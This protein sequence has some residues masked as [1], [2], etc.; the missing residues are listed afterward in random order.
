ML[1]A[2]AL[3]F[4]A[5]TTSFVVYQGVHWEP[6]SA[7]VEVT[8]NETNFTLTGNETHPCWFSPGHNITGYWRGRSLLPY[9]QWATWNNS[10]DWDGDNISDEDEPLFGTDICDWDSDN[11][12]LS[13]FI[14]IYETFSDP[15]ERDTDGDLLLDAWDPAP[16]NDSHDADNDGVLDQYDQW[17]VEDVI[18]NLTFDWNW[19]GLQVIA[20][21]ILDDELLVSI[22]ESSDANGSFVVT[23][24]D[25]PDNYS[26][27][28][29]VNLS[30]DGGGLN[31]S[32]HVLNWS[33][34][35]LFL[36]GSGRLIYHYNGSRGNLTIEVNH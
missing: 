4:L 15:N 32:S 26:T 22:Y 13:D 29:V 18:R 27:D 35:P 7:P 2:F 36:I 24:Y 31:E 10:T 8:E 16:L 1:K 19:T 11:D 30:I 6:A 25:W 3:V 14:E 17:M 28:P 9:S 34:H 12:T 20:D 5:A 33:Q 23:D 21:F